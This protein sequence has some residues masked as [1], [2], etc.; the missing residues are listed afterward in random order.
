[1]SNLGLPE[2]NLA[3]STFLVPLVCGGGLLIGFFFFLYIFSKTRETLH[4]AMALLGAGAFALVFS[5]GLILYFGAVER[6]IVLGRQFHRIEQLAGLTFL[7]SLPYFLG[8]FLHLEGPVGRINTGINLVGLGLVILIGSLAFISPDL[9]ISQAIPY[10]SWLTG[11]GDYGRGRTGVLY[12]VR[13]LALALEFL[14]ALGLVLSHLL[15]RGRSREDL[16]LFVGLVIV[17]FQALDDIIFVYTNVHIGPFPQVSYSRFSLGVTVFVL[18]AMTAL[19]RRYIAGATKTEEAYAAAE[20]SR[21]E[22]RFQAYHDGLTGLGNRKA[23]LERLEESLAMA[24]RSESERLR[25]IILVDCGGHKDLADRL[26]Q[27]VGEWLILET[28]ARL[29]AIKR[30]SDLLF[31]LDGS[32]FALLLTAIKDETDCA[33]VAEKICRDL[34]KAYVSASHT[35]YLRPRVGIAVYPKD[36]DTAAILARDAGA[37]L[38]EASALYAAAGPDDATYLFYT[39]ALHSRATE[40]MKLLHELRRALE[41]QEFELHLQPQVGEGGRVVGS[42]ALVRWNHPKLGRVSPA[43]FIPLAEETGLIIPLGRWIFAE[44]CRLSRLSREAG[45][46]LPLS[47]NLSAQQLKDGDLVARMAGDLKANA[48]PRGRLHVEITESSLMRDLD[49]N[50]EAINSIRALGCDFSIDDFGTGYSSLS[51]LKNLPVETLKID[52]SFV[53]GLP[54]SAQDCA[55]VTAIVSLCKGLGLSMIAEGV[56][57]QDQLDFLHSVDCRIIQGFL[58]SRPLSFDSYLDYVRAHGQ[59]LG[60]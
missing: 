27:E 37:A 48:I 45:I 51:Y 30:N 50:L 33:I 31:R 5:E 10:P 59:A 36:G 60:A 34:G 17:I 26:G 23:F 8:R 54:G 19:M 12:L 38:A 29:K 39:P 14:Y 41:A 21:A 1:M 20:R 4:L 44:A 13:D 24:T 40:R 3:F 52:R 56:D 7:A 46:D 9:F 57:S 6:D 15:G 43:T 25:G 11:G 18:V 32:E 22:L 58:F 55:L 42:E 16:P 53:L 2:T 35:L 28:Q 49:R 47:V